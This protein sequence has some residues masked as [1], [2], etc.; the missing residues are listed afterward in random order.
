MIRAFQKQGFFLKKA[1]KTLKDF[2]LECS[3]SQISHRNI[4]V[5]TS[6][7]TLSASSSILLFSLLYFAFQNMPYHPKAL[8]IALSY[9]LL[10]SRHLIDAICCTISLETE[11]ISLQR[12]TALE[13][14]SKKPLIYSIESKKNQTKDS[15]SSSLIT[16]NGVYLKYG[17][18]PT[19]SLE[20]ISFSIKKGEKVAFCGRTGSGKSSIFSLLFK[21]YP[22]HN[23][24][25]LYQDKDLALFEAKELRNSIAMIPQNGFLFKGTLK[26]NFDPNNRF[27]AKEIEDILRDY[28]I[29]DVFIGK[30]LD[31][32]VEKEGGNLSNGEKQMVNFLQNVLTEKPV[33]L[34]DEATSNLD[35]KLDQR[36]MNLL[37]KICQN[38]TLLLISHRLENLDF[39]DRIH[40]LEKGQIKESGTFET[41]S[42]EPLSLFNSLKTQL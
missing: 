32:M 16:F 7:L 42:K 24:Q 23:G 12:L 10:L 9:S 25:I 31:F 13:I 20:N 28:E 18:T 8:G 11:L 37:R 21:F 34:L 4:V 26:E 30:S 33:I 14:A 41:L 15:F 2:L 29:E 22:Y 39:F 1:M 17:E 35:E 27:K 19:F 36:I 6:L 38:K 5:Q 3:K 40:V